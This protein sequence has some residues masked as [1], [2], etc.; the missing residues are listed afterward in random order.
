VAST[1]AEFS[2]ARSRY[3]DSLKAD[4]YKVGPGNVPTNADKDSA[5]SL[6]ISRA[7][8][9][10]LFVPDG[11]RLAAQTLGAKFEKHTRDFIQDTFPKLTHLRPGEWTIACITNRTGLDI[12]DYEQYAHLREVERAAQA[13]PA[14]R[15]LLG[16]DYT[17]AS[18]VVITRKPVDDA[19]INSAVELVDAGVARRASIRSAN[20]SKPSL[21]ACLSCKWT[22]RSDRAQNSRSEALRL[23]RSR[24]GRVPHIAVI[25]A[26]PLPSRLAS[27]ALGT[28]D[29]DCVYHIALPELQRAVQTINESEAEALL[30]LMIDG[31]RLKDIADLPLDLAI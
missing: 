9:S 21:H 23:I 22:M 10:A 25:T 16:S 7:L 14:L 5:T 11:P 28:G 19:Q 24:K 18:D 20:D 17:I 13:Q 29:I 8:A 31:R 4:V 12:G 27:I 1:V 30:A 2:A 6:R 3:H 26:E 15:V